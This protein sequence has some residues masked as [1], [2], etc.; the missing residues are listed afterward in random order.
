M[1]LTLQCGQNSLFIQHAK[2]YV[3][4][5]KSIFTLGLWNLLDSKLSLCGISNG[6][7]WFSSSHNHLEFMNFKLKFESSIEKKSHIFSI[8]GT[9]KDFRGP[10]GLEPWWDCVL[11]HVYAH[12]SVKRAL[13]FYTSVTF[14]EGYVKDICILRRISVFFI[15]K[16]IY[17]EYKNHYV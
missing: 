17:K 10:R 2:G 3:A 12:F 4:G 14:S 9:W 13:D 11:F 7:G 16:Y 15:Y 8:W 6:K 5:L 1:N